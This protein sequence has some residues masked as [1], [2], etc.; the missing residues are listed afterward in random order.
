VNAAAVISA[1]DLPLGARVDRR[2]PKT[3]LVEH[4]AT[5]TAD[6]RCINEGIEEVQWVATLK[7]TTISVPTF[8]DNVREYLEIAV[9][10]V[11]LRAEAKT[12]RLAELI[13]RA[14]PYPVFL[15]VAEPE[16]LALSLAHKRWSQGE[17]G[18]TVLDGD[19]MAVTL[20]NAEPDGP[21]ASF[22]QAL[23]L[24]RQ[25][26]ANLYELYQGW[27]DTVLALLA[28]EVTGHFELTGSAAHAVARRAALRE[29][30][31]CDVEIARLRA[32]AAK[33]R[34]VSRL[35]ELNVALKHAEAARV[36]ALA[37]L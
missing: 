24:A 31:Q 9:L 34:Q 11:V 12:T 30:T 28:A 32:A 15:I 23:S 21:Q 37:Q 18:A 1:L 6:K 22:R 14:V 4:G 3:L 8:R 7:P 36:A 19:S 16:S 2:I 10:S 25:P 5:T 17:A 35:V 20:T 29:Y 13:H 27:L 33:E 26:R